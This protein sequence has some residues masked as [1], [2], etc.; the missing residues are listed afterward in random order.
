MLASRLVASDRSM[1]TWF[2]TV[3]LLP[4]GYWATRNVPPPICSGLIS[5]DVVPLR[6]ARA[7][8]DSFGLL[9]PEYVRYDVTLARDE[10]RADWWRLKAN[11]TPGPTS[12]SHV[13]GDA[14]SPEPG[15]NCGLNLDSRSRVK[16]QPLNSVISLRSQPSCLLLACRHLSQEMFYI[17]THV[18]TPL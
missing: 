11:K 2:Y 16:T 15:N 10:A 14:V 7:P 13:G 8:N 6:A 5:P 1:L 3:G 18:Y 9:K 4:P 17:S 12:A